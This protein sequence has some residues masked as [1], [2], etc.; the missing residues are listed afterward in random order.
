MSRGAPRSPA[1]RHRELEEAG[2][3]SLFDV[4]DLD[5][6]DAMAAE[7]D[8]AATIQARF[9]RFHQANPSVYRELVAM[10]R[11]LR[12]AGHDRFGLRMLWETLRWRRMLA[13][14]DPSGY[15]LNDNYISR[16]ARLI[17]RREPD[18]AG[19]FE[20]RAIRAQ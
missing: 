18:L 19:V 13:T 11:E 16:Y 1:D 20:T 4:F 14:S 2:Q 6:L 7:G 9:V 12:S 3:G 17:M 8:R 15:K 5:T 10:A